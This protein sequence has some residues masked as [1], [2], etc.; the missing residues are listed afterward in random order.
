MNKL[1]V[2]HHS[3]L[4]LSR[5]HSF[6]RSIF[7]SQLRESKHLLLSFFWLFLRSSCL[8]SKRGK[9]NHKPLVFYY[10]NKYFFP[11]WLSAKFSSSEIS[12][13][14]LIIYKVWCVS[15][16]H[17]A[18]AISYSRPWWPLKAF[19]V[20]WKTVLM[21]VVGERKRE[22]FAKEINTPNTTHTHINMH[23]STL[24]WE[25]QASGNKVAELAPR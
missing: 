15:T 21:G 2:L 8:T 5:S 4:H 19:S 12:R 20:W 10:W 18:Q 9:T 11:Q 13:V 17:G 7:C 23:V 16:Q 22:Y 24:L 1:H 14:W 25:K 3:R 6:F